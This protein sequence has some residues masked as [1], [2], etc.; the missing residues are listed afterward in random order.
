[1]SGFIALA[2]FFGAGVLMAALVYRRRGGVQ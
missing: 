2:C 1:V